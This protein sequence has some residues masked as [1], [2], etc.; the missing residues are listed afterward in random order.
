MSKYNVK[1]I[2]REEIAEGTMAFFLEKPAGF[3]FKA[4]QHIEVTL[5]KPPESDAEG[6]TRTL[7]IASSPQEKNLMVA[8]RMRD[9]AFKRVIKTLPEETELKIEG[10]F[11]SFFLHNDS[12]YEAIFLIGGIGITPIRS[13]ILSAGYEKL[14][15]HLFLFYSNRRPE[16]AAFLN[17]L[18]QAEKENPNFKLITTI[19]EMEKSKEKWSGETG[20]INKEMLTKYLNDLSHPIY[21]ISGP[22]QMVKAMRKILN[23][24]KVNDDDIRTEEF[25]GY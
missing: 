11:G 8:T 23:E 1:L 2:K 4:G 21:Y 15:H 7:S 5:I 6:N 14:A 20:Y 24:A 25:S 18:Q 16:D 17:E 3:Q 12:S 22:P 19:T 9:T 13:I 10:P